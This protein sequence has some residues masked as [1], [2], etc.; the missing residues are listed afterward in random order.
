MKINYVEGT[1]FAI[2]LRNGG[3]AVGLVA[4]ATSEGPHLLAYMFGPKRDAV[5][6][7]D[8]VVDLEPSS[9]VKVARTGDLKLINGTWPIIGHLPTFRRSAWPFPKFVRTEE[10]ARRAWVVEYG[11]DDPG[12]P[13][14]EVP[15]PFGTSALDRDMSFGAGAVELVLTKL[16]ERAP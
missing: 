2:P 9:A 11:D 4:R 1:W 3:F 16:L 7:I 8:D 14:S 15:T 5:P 13:I 10:L 12:C 6:T